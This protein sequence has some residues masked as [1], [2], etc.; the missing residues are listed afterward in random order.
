MKIMGHFTDQDS[1]IFQTSSDN[2]A[3]TITPTTTLT[4][5]SL[6]LTI[7][8]PAGTTDVLVSRTSSDT[9]TNKTLTA[10][11][12]ATIING[13]A[14]L[15]LPTST[16]TILGRATT[17]TL[18][19]K[20]LTSPV[21]STP[22]ITSGTATALTGLSLRD[23]SAAFNLTLAAVSSPA[24]TANRTLTLNMADSGATFNFS[25]ATN[26]TFPTSGTLAANSLATPTVAGIV[27]SYVPTVASAIK[28]VS[29]ANYVILTADGFDT[30]L[31]STGASDRTITLP[32]ASSNA[33]RTLRF[34][35]TDSGAGHVIVTRAGS[36]TIDAN[37]TRVLVNQYDAMI[38]T[39]NGGTNYSVIKHPNTSIVF[40]NS[41]TG[42][43]AQTAGTQKNVFG[44][45]SGLGITLQPGTW[46]VSAQAQLSAV[47]GTALPAGNGECSII[48]SATEDSGTGSSVGDDTVRMQSFITSA[49]IAN[50]I[51]M[52]QLVIA[53]TKIT[54]TTATNYYL[55]GYHGYSGN[56]PTWVSRLSAQCVG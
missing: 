51:R 41:G 5:A 34:Q 48:V 38:I 10:P 13:A 55:N 50:N 46:L 44:A 17:D 25:G 43:T 45:A 1:T 47:T 7:P 33:G 2:K 9:L 27:T 56:A 30:I 42:V 11:T 37:T 53:S 54:V 6:A 36:D 20:T 8:N 23:T 4:G 12:I 39:C 19:N 14:T 15:T 40:N 28:S 18:T 31:V 22:A 24:L 3:V 21:I 52:I 32:A 16:D 49:Q 35:K 29:S 26:I